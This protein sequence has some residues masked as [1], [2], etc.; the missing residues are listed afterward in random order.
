MVRQAPRGL[1]GQKR[2]R[3]RIEAKG[4]SSLESP[5]LVKV[6]AMGRTHLIH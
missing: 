4:G 1:F 3:I 6:E 5:H 2:P